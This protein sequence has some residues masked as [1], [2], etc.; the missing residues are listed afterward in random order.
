MA[1]PNGIGLIT[2]GSRAYS[3]KLALRWRKQRR[4]RCES[5]SKEEGGLQLAGEHGHARALRV[6]EEVV[7]DRGDVAIPGRDLHDLGQTPPL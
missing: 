1:W 6:V 5:A 3:R 2:A 4:E 7:Q